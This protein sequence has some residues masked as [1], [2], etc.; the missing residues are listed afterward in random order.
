MWITP[1]IASLPPWWRLLQ[2]IRRYKDSRESVHLI[3]GGKYLTSI[4]AT[5]LTG[6]R[7]IHSKF[8]SEKNSQDSKT[9]V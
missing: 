4:W 9:F 1:I 6:A 7:R 2:C 5:A 3:N 8:H